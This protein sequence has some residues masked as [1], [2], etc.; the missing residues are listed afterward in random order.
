M[1][2]F[3]ATVILAL[4]G[5]SL[6]GN[7]QAAVRL[8]DLNIP[9]Q[10]LDTALKEFGRQTGLQIARFTDTG[11]A[12]VSVGPISGAHS[13]HQALTM[14]LTELNLTYRV[15]NERTIAVV[16][17]AKGQDKA[18]EPTPP[19]VSP[20]VA[21]NPT[22]EAS[23]PLDE[24]PIADGLQ[25][26]VVSA[27]RRAES[28][29]NIPL[30]VSVLGNDR[31][32]NSNIQTLADV[33]ARVP[34]FSVNNS[35]GPVFET[36]SMRG[37]GIVSG[38][39]ASAGSAAT[40]AVYIN[41]TPVTPPFSRNSQAQPNVF[42]LDR[43]EVLRGPQGTL[44]GASS[45]GGTI[46]YI[47]NKPDLDR[48]EGKVALELSQYEAFGENQAIDALVNV[49]L[50]EGRMAIR[51]SLSYHKDA[52]F[53]D[54]IPLSAGASVPGTLPNPS[55][56]ALLQRNV[57][58]VETRE[59]R[60]AFGWQLTDALSITQTVSSNDID[61]SSATTTDRTLGL[62]LQ[63]RDRDE[64]QRASFDY[65]N[66]EANYD[67]ERFAVVSSTSYMEREVVEISYY[68]ALLAEI[69]G[70]PLEDM[71]LS[72]SADDLDS[73]RINPQR[74]FV[75]E[76]R[77]QSPDQQRFTWL[78]GG[79]FLQQKGGEAQNLLAPTYAAYAKSIGLFD[80]SAPDYT[81]SESRRS[82]ESQRA[83]FGNVT[84]RLTDDLKLSV[85]ARVTD[86][87][88]RTLIQT[89]G[90]LFGDASEQTE[91]D[92][93]PE[94]TPSASLTWTIT[95]DNMTYVSYGE[96][97]RVGI[98]QTPITDGPCATSLLAIGVDPAAS[99]G[100]EGDSLRNYEIG[101]KNAWANRRFRANVAA[102]LIDWSDIQQTINLSCG[103]G[104][105]TNAGSAEI[106]GLEIE[107]AWAATER[108]LLDL[109]VGYTDARVTSLGGFDIPGQ[110]VGDRLPEVPRLTVASG[111]EYGFPVRENWDGYVRGQA[112][113]RDAVYQDFAQSADFR[114]PSYLLG[115]F[116]LGV[117]NEDWD[118]T[119]FVNNL[120]NKRYITVLGIESATWVP[121]RPRTLGIRAAYKF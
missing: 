3:C 40:V 39:Q 2:L 25:E 28:V 58:D 79:F 70:V 98:D 30:S 107:L 114:R 48:F 104:F 69:A 82:K 89:G 117:R 18:T 23:R 41:E 78:L 120:T 4:L 115:D 99:G 21:A 24:S 77:I 20:P 91:E 15:V 85:G 13:M 35:G 96:G 112:S 53:I 66:L 95:P 92:F 106:R 17:L 105:V 22:A 7:G 5:A 84:Y 50:V 56:L 12:D 68:G 29:Q 97:F 34:G 14:M 74:L 81:Y 62:Y 110:S 31:L 109:A 76:L 75:Q 42:D 49:P 44:F 118:V 27:T 38:G 54:R 46:R 60:I 71:L 103:S 64:P 83:V 57:N 9:R 33:A 47:L 100:V 55:L 11:T 36:L 1:K 61:L 51:T 63:S 8:Y 88:K 121:G 59:A 37:V 45:M 43:I 102:Y 108:T 93:D 101:S 119:W 116:R 72:V 90:A 80:P 26:V 32:E 65:F 73:D 16:P 86:V 52:G 19:P 111:V 67:A 87:K 113:W 6:P 10:S 94:V